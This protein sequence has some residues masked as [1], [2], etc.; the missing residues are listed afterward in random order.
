MERVEEEHMERANELATKSARKG[1]GPFGCVITGMNYEKVAEGN[2]RVTED[3][4]PTAHAEI[5]AI[6]RACNALGTFDLT[7][8]RLFTSCE[9]C[10][11]CLSAIYWSRIKD[12]YY[13]STRKDAANIGFDDE[14][15][16]DELNKDLDDRSVHLKRVR[17][18]N[19]GDSFSLWMASEDKI[20]Y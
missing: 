11:M 8:C 20:A 2:N 3:N 12:V 1:T 13:G 16:Y 19:E 4:D 14:F 5:V 6:R 15:I 18:Y 10:P 7:G 17:S 9:P